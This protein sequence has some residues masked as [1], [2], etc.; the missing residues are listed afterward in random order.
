[1]TS[2][3]DIVAADAQRLEKQMGVKELRFSNDGLTWLI[4]EWID[5]FQ[6]LEFT[7]VDGRTWN[8]D[9]NK[10]H[11]LMLYLQEHLK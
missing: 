2:W 10:A 8:L 6:R 4:V 5:G 1:M 11:L 9:R 3:P 7:E